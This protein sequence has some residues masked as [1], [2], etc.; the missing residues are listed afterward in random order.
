VG[1]RAFEVAALCRPVD[2]RELEDFG[3]IQDDSGVWTFPGW[4]TVEGILQTAPCLC[5]RRYDG[6]SGQVLLRRT[7]LN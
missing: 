7:R 3:A 4:L 5:Q 2:D 1:T 6:L